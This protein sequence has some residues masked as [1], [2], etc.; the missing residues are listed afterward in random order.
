M[1]TLF[2][3]LHLVSGDH[4]VHNVNYATWGECFDAAAKVEAANL[5]KPHVMSVETKCVEALEG[6]EDL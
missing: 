2:V 5:E 3:L 6:E 4:A 1:I